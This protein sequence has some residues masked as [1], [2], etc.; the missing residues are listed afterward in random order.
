MALDAACCY[1]RSIMWSVGHDREPRKNDWTD[2]GAVWLWTQ[3][4][5][6]TMC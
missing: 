3:V 2:R 6:G 4:V 5:Q 1:R